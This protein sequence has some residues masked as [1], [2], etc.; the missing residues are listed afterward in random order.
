LSAN[1]IVKTDKTEGFGEK[2]GT[3]PLRRYTGNVRVKWY[4]TRK[5]WRLIV[6]AHFTGTG[7]KQFMLFK[8]KPEGEAEIRRILNRGSSS[9]PQTSEAD[10]AAITLA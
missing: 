10:E 9:R 6:P 3:V 8:S 5:R 2:G 7:R 1:W 4:E